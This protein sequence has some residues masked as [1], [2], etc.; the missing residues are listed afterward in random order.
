[1][2]DTVLNLCKDSVREFVQFMLSYIPE[3]TTISSTAIVYNT[4]IK[5]K[6]EDPEEESQNL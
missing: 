6:A 4:F 3:S 2:Q 1:M 5:T